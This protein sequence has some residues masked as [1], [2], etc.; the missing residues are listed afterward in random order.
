MKKAILDLGYDSPTPIQTETIPLLLKKS[1]DFLGL[2]ATGTGKTAAYSI[3]L[4][5]NMKSTIKGVQA[6]VLC[7]TR[8]LAKQVA[9]QMNLLARYKKPKQSPFTVV[10]TTADSCAL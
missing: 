2:A 7:P 8:E 1:T 10:L 5:E 9:E 6:L 3:P 4:L